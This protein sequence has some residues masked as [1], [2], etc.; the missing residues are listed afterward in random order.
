MLSF[1]STFLL[2]I[3][4]LATGAA[5]ALADPLAKPACLD[6][7]RLTTLSSVLP[8]AD[9]Q[10][11]APVISASSSTSPSPS[12]SLIQGVGGVI[13]SQVPFVSGS[14]ACTYPVIRGL[15]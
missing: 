7:H 14:P 1:R 12:P 2:L 8:A 3:T 11:T 13:V 10:V 15:W 9:Q 5:P 6:P 4:G